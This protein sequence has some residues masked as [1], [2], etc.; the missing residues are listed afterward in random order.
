[1]TNS[2]VLLRIACIVQ[3]NHLPCLMGDNYHHERFTL[4]LSPSALCTLSGLQAALK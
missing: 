1:M 4:M 2:S 3:E